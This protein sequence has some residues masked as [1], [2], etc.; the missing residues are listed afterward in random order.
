[1]FCCLSIR[2]SLVREKSMLFSHL[3]P[4]TKSGVKNNVKLG[5]LAVSKPGN[6]LVSWMSHRFYDSW[7]LK[8]ICCNV[9][10][11]GV[12]GFQKNRKFPM[13]IFTSYYSSGTG[14]KNELFFSCHHFRSTHFLI[15]FFFSLRSLFVG[16]HFLFTE[17]CFKNNYIYSVYSLSS[18]RI[19]LFF[20]HISLP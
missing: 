14:L 7:S 8:Q 4:P 10:V 19:E 11:L 16:F 2:T 9:T 6:L 13:G 5:I 18:D 20:S 3:P 12:T 1:M 17:L 15:F